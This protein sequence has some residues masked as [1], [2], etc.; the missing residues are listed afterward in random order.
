MENYKDII[1]QAINYNAILMRPTFSGKLFIDFPNE[2]LCTMFVERLNKLHVNFKC[3]I[4]TINPSSIVID[5]H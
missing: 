2:G 5:I 1:L 3:T 4:G